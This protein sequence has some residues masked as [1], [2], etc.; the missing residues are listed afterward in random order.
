M[1]SNP[2]RKSLTQ[3]RDRSSRGEVARGDDWDV[4]DPGRAPLDVSCV[5]SVD[6]A[7]QEPE[8]EE[9]LSAQRMEDRVSTIAGPGSVVVRPCRSQIRDR[10]SR[11]EVARGDDWDVGDPGRAPLDRGADNET[12]R[13]GQ[14]EATELAGR[15][16]EREVVGG[17]DEGCPGDKT[18]DEFGAH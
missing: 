6:E 8:S 2:E 7:S 18:D 16:L 13:D 9:G 4:G 14:E 11:G 17:K 15:L 3:I 1:P 10:S 12:D 5:F